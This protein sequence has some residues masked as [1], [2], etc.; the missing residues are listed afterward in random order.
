[1]RY[2]VSHRSAVY[3]IHYPEEHASLALR[4]DDGSLTSVG[5]GITGACNLGNGASAHMMMTFSPRPLSVDISEDGRLAVL[6]FELED[7]DVRYG[8]SFIDAEQAGRNL[9]A[10][11]AEK[12]LDTVASEGRKIWNE[13][14]SK[15]EVEGTECMRGW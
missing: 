8:V 4:V 11:V 12:S 15:I 7:V 5:D 3:S 10:E 2:A 1:M 6:G 13:A 9:S 14:L